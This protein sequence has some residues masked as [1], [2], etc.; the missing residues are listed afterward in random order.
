MRKV[1]LREE[2]QTLQNCVTDEFLDLR[3]YL[4]Q[5]GLI[6]I[7]QIKI[8]EI[9]QVKQGIRLEEILINLGFL[10]DQVLREIIANSKG[11]SIFNLEESIIDVHL[12]VNFPKNIAEDYQVLPMFY[13]KETL[14]AALVDVDD[15]MALDQLRRFFPHI[16]HIIPYVATAPDLGQA[17]D[18]AYGHALSIEGLLQEI[19]T[20]GNKDS[21]HIEGAASSFINTILI[22]AVKRKASDI[23]FEPEGIFVRCRYRL[24]GVLRQICTFHRQYWSMLLIRL[25][26]M[27]E[28]DITE[29]RLPH[30]GRF[31]FIVANREVDFRAASHPT[32][33]GENFVVRILDKR[34]SLLPLENLGFKEDSIHLIK[35]LIKTPQGLIVVTGP[36]GSGKTTTLYSILQ[37][38][39]STD[40]N[41]MTLEEPVEYE[42]PLIRQTEVREPGGVSFI[43][44]IRSILRQ[45]PDIIFIGEVRDDETAKMALRAAM[46]GHLVLT[47][48]H[49][50]NAFD[51]IARFKDLGLS[52]QMLA[53]HLRGVIAQR[54][55]RKLCSF[56]KFETKVNEKE[57]SIFQ[58]YNQENSVL[59][60]AEG[61]Q[62]C[63]FTG[64][65]GR[66]AVAETLVFD[67]KM[68]SLLSEGKIFELRDYAQAQGFQSM[69]QA[70]LSLVREGGVNM[71]EIERVIGLRKI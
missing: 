40:V 58:K 41:I 52:A 60:K 68:D 15:L 43:E 3:A 5:S 37:Y 49:T 70:G 61:C 8:A 38:I 59:Y 7:D 30:H 50:N 56:C 28:M 46:T 45:D 51:I 39:A 11:I 6:S 65:H 31:S 14:H 9:E 29:S 32:V 26:I 23:H 36:T 25:K 48:L 47:T 10:S 17:I 12:L 55:L 54:L 64:Y 66:I 53:G 67:E 34:H 19:E 33:H 16:I 2:S 44:G 4:L 42:L 35:Q 18:K 20:K 69:M 27:S 21:F 63:G 62:Q 71:A 13:E 24:D 22:D 57:Q 1:V